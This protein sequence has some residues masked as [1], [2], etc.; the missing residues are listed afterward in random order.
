MADQPASGKVYSIEPSSAKKPSAKKMYVAP[1]L[2][3]WGTLRDQTMSVGRNGHFDGGQG[4]RKFT[5]A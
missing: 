5:R 3:R 2:L 4:T 1:C